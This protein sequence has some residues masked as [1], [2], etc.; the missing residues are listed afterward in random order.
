MEKKLGRYAK[1]N[2]NMYVL[3]YGANDL[4][5]NGNIANY[6]MRIFDMQCCNLFFFC[7]SSHDLNVQMS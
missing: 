6:S 1:C 7:L 2:F 4:T 5:Y 3:M